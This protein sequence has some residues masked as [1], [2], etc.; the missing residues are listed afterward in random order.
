MRTMR[1]WTTV[2]L[3]L[4]MLTSAS[5]CDDGSEGRDDV[6]I[7]P[8]TDHDEPLDF[9]PVEGKTDGVSDSFDKNLVVT[10]AFFTASN[11][12]T[13]AQ[14]QAFLENTPYNKRSFL[15]DETVGGRKFSEV[16]VEVAQGRGINPVMLLSRMQVEKSLIAKTT[17]PSGN[18]VDFAFGCGCPDN[19]P[20]NEAYRGIDKQVD[21][22][23]K[24][25]QTHYDGSIAGSGQW[26]VGKTKN[27]LDPIAVTPQSHATASLYAYTPWVLT[28]SGGNW[29]VWNITK[30]YAAALEIQVPTGPQPGFVGS[31]CTE[32]LESL[33]AE[34]Q[35]S[36]ATCEFS[37]SGET[38]YCYPFTTPADEQLGVCTL[39][40]AGYCPDQGSATTFCTE[41]EA[42]AGFCVLK[43]SSTNADCANVPGTVVQEV[44]RFVGTSGAA[45]STARVCMPDKKAS[46]SDPPPTEDPTDPTGGS[47]AGVCGSSDPVA[48]GD[49]TSCYCDSGCA[50]FGDCCSDYQTTCG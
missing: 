48:N 16:L 2:T 20:C 25:L 35:A 47:C 38:G 29:L 26:R 46:E 7:E 21:C 12:V 31:P 28:G 22:A 6:R 10:D 15:A 3:G 27:T 4:V 32:D 36:F 33:P 30:R 50:E 13:P 19:Q 5:A 11:A 44:D 14:I 49:G 34:Q 40:C 9:E 37:A 24:T 18:A 45:A 17:R 8:Y 43:A 1:L 39:T 41:L 42:G 23:A